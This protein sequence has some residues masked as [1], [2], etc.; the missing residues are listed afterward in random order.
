MTLRRDDDQIVTPPSVPPHQRLPHGFYVQSGA[1]LTLAPGRYV[2]GGRYGRLTAGVQP[3]TCRAGLSQKASSRLETA[4]FAV[5]LNP[6]AA[7]AIVVRAPRNGWI[8][9]DR[10]RRVVGCAQVFYAPR[11]GELR[12]EHVIEVAEP[13]TLGISASP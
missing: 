2:V 5:I 10:E 4:E 6:G 1:P 12:F 11:A 9:I 3:V 8:Q 7:R 13:R